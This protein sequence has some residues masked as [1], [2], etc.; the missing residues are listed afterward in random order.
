[1]EENVKVIE[2]GYYFLND[3]ISTLLREGS[4]V[5]DVTYNENKKSYLI[6]AQLVPE[7]QRREKEE[8]WKSDYD[9]LKFMER[10]INTYPD[11]RMAVRAAME[12][13]DRQIENYLNRFR[14]ALQETLSNKNARELEEL[15]TVMWK[16]LE[17]VK[18]Y[19]LAD[20]STSAVNNRRNSE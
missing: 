16:I 9:R 1:M 2:A 10:R 8:A 13:D 11:L 4:K 7:S 5:L 14:E 3:K 12:H 6:K 17:L 18:A 19:S 20:F 15:K